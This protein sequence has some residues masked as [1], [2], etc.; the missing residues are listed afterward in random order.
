MPT[1][2]PESAAVARRLTEVTREAVAAYNAA[3]ARPVG[4]LPV[5]RYP[6]GREKR[7]REVRRVLRVAREVCAAEYGEPQVT[8]QFWADYFAACAADPFLSGRQGG[9]RGHEGW[10]PDFEYLTR[11]ATMLR[12]YERSTA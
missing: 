7:E 8:A 11:E 10:L 1:K 9:G 2:P 4:L 5:V 12:V 3:L 6:I